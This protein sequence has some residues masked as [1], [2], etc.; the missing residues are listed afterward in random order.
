[1][2]QHDAQLPFALEYNGELIARFH[3]FRLADC[4]M[5]LLCGE[6]KQGTTLKL[7]NDT[8]T[9]LE[10]NAEGECVIDKTEELRNDIERENAGSD[11][12]GN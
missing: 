10:F 7:R 1:M 2:T 8:N 6:A 3:T 4:V 9:L 5:D 11:P 12:S